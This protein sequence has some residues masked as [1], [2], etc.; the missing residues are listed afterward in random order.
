MTTQVRQA[1]GGLLLALLATSPA[2]A[3][4]VTVEYYHVDAVGSVRA[5]TDASGAVVRRHDYFPFGEEWN[6]LPVSGDARRFTGKE[7]DAETAL[8]YFGAR[9]YGARTARFTTVDPVFTWEENLADPQRWNRY[10]Y[11]RNNPLRYTDPDGR[12]IRL[13]TGYSESDYARNAQIRATIAAA[14][15]PVSE[16]NPLMS[17]GVTALDG[18][19]SAFFPASTREVAEAANAAV[20]GMAIPLQPGEI[21][22]GKGFTQAQKR[23]I[24]DLNRARHGGELRSDLSGEQ[25]VPA[26]Q[27]QRGVTPPPNEAQVD[28]VYPR[29]RG[30]SNT[31]DNSQVL[32]RQENRAK[33][34]KVPE[35]K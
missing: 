12:Q 16:S 10:A 18:L 8:D 24:L 28:H 23:R 15:A 30:G 31:V 9:Y 6:P 32:S 5:V 21:A 35:T 4:P 20:F 13:S 19:L 33:S 27:S 2:A 25:L 34:N 14:L 7:R 22:A 3:Q 26:R 1:F 29:S 17:A 11:V